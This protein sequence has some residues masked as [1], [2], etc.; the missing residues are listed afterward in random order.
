MFLCVFSNAQTQSGRSGEVKFE[1]L[2]VIKTETDL[3]L[4]FTLNAH[5]ATVNTQAMIE[6]IP[7]LFLEDM[8]EKHE[9]EPIV[10]VGSKRNRAL[11][12]ELEFGTYRFEKQPQ[13]YLCW[14]KGR[15]ESQQIDL[16]LP[17]AEWMRNARLSV[18]EKV[19]GC[20][21]CDLGRG[22]YEVADRVLPP[23]FSP[24]YELQYVVPE[25]EQ[26]KRR[27]ETYTAYLNY[28]VGDHKL[29]RD[30]E[31]NA[32][33]LDRVDKIVREIRMD[34]NLTVQTLN[35]IGYASPEGVYNSNLELSKKR[36]FSFVDYLTKIHNL[37]QSLMKT[38]WKGEDWEGLRKSI[39]TSSLED[40][41]EVLNIIS[42]KDVAQ[43]KA[44][45][46][47][48]NQGRT[49]Q[50]L[51]KNYYPVLRRNEYTIAYVA[52][53][54]NIEEAKEII[55]TKPQH[56]SLNEMFLVANSYEENSEEFKNVFD[57]AVTL[58]PEDPV[59]NINAA[60]QEIESGVLNR[61]IIRLKDINT[62]EAWNN[63]GVAYA[64]RRD[65]EQ[66]E[67]CFDKAYSAGNRV[68]GENKD[69]LK[70]FLAN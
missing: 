44:R 35:I 40:K 7:V 70:K 65:Y 56:L 34:D 9:F 19:T 12:R 11:Q 13:K 50:F 28:K 14:K 69:Q 61:A 10:I 27:S 1:N 24:S 23:L 54:F 5:T 45:L 16:S 4:S 3:N 66:A 63:L 53:P 46:K 18:I 26:V 49:Y 47:E 32:E 48:L 64:K 59:A 6:L 20:A 31:N 43:R 17:Y 33:A 22:E 52:R 58:F 42:E 60:A 15:V 25:A 37:N 8:S 51:L 36:A 62:P 2:Q 68:A 29:M 41:H 39:E 21:D 38:D 55:R 57:V 67:T 30:F